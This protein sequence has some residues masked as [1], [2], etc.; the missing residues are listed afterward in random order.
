MRTTIHVALHLGAQ[1]GTD[2]LFQLLGKE[3]Q[4]IGT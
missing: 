4:H 3:S 1:L 2:L